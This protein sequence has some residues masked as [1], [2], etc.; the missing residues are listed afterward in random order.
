[1]T[2]DWKKHTKRIHSFLYT[3]FSLTLYTII[4]YYMNNNDNDEDDN[5][6]NNSQRKN[7]NN[8]NFH[9]E[10]GF[11]NRASVQ[12]EDTSDDGYSFA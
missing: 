3:T 7:N 5:N 12:R 1:M 6:T 8:L 10:K 2:E 11:S 4:I 9:G